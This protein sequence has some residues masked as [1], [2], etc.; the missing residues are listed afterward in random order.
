MRNEH[1]ID[2]I[3]WFW[4]STINSWEMWQN[5][6]KRA[7]NMRIWMISTLDHKWVRV[8]QQKFLS[9]LRFFAKL[10]LEIL[11]SRWWSDTK[12]TNLKMCFILRKSLQS[13]PNEHINDTFDDFGMWPQIQESLGAEMFFLCLRFFAKTFLEQVVVWL[14]NHTS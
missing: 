7:Y 12:I 4:H 3:R 8:S 14:K 1:I 13:R 11:H 10:F 6:P 5:G 9:C 2:T